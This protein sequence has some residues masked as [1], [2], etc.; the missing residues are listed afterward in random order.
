MNCTCCCLKDVTDRQEK[1][2]RDHET[3]EER[4]KKCRDQ[5]K[6]KKKVAK[7]LLTTA[8]KQAEET[9][10]LGDRVETDRNPESIEIEISKIEK[11]LKEEAWRCVCVY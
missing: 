1:V 8:T 7:Q 6:E 5:L 3:Y 4:L 9:A 2:S 10:E 11:K